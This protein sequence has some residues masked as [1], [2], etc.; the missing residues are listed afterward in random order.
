MTDFL[1]WIALRRVHGGRVATVAGCWVDRGRPVPGYLPAILNELTETGL[2]TLADVDSHGL[3][4]ASLAET[5][6]TRYAAL[7]EH[8][9][10]H[11][12]R[13]EREA[14]APDIRVCVDCRPPKPRTLNAIGSVCSVLEGVLRRGIILRPRRHTKSKASRGLVSRTIV[15]RD[16]RHPTGRP[17][18]LKVDIRR[19]ELLDTE[20]ATA[21]VAARVGVPLPHVTVIDVSQ[22]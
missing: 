16:T 4:R 13:A 17:Q 9:G 1:T 14:P 19:G 22:D 18:K 8:H 2:V 6:Q 7:L 12:A 10:A 5:G 11:I 3:R 20:Q 21:M 15:Y